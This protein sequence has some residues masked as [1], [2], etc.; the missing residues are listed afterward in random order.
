MIVMHS[1]HCYRCDRRSP[2]HRSLPPSGTSVVATLPTANGS[3]G[4]NTMSTDKLGNLY[5]VSSVTNSKNEYGRRT[6]IRIDIFS[7]PLSL[8]LI[9]FRICVVVARSLSF[10]F[11]LS[12][13]LYHLQICR[14]HLC[15]I[16][17]YDVGTS[18]NI[19]TISEEATMRRD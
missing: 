4:Q 3:T 7:W 14:R 11:S 12:S 13:G 6:T 16:D 10:S 19:V 18:G 17:V 9:R 1:Y 2:L 15:T 5:I 8:F